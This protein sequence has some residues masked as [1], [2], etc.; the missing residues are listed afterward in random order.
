M[1]IRCPTNSC[2]LDDMDSL[3]KDNEISLPPF[4][5]KG[6]CFS[7][8]FPL[9]NFACESEIVTIVETYILG[10]TG[11]SWPQEKRNK[12]RFWK[13]G[14]RWSRP[15]ITGGETTTSSKQKG[16]NKTRITRGLSEG[17]KTRVTWP[18]TQGVGGLSQCV[19]DGDLEKVRR[20]V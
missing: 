6:T 3:Q 7:I 15:S 8:T 4:D 9:S 12:Q 20:G 2:L 19:V 14:K 5:W 10:A 16:V 13:G 1:P 11:C 17:P 18:G